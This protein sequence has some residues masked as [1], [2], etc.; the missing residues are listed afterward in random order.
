M[1]LGFLGRASYVPVA[2]DHFGLASAGY[3]HFT[4]P[5]RRYADLAVHR[6]IHA[7]LAGG[8]D[9][10]SFPD[11]ASMGALC[12]HINT[13][14]R[15]ASQAE[16]QMR[17]SLWMAQL[18]AAERD[19][20]YP[21]RVTGVGPKGVFVTLD[22]SRVSGM[23]STREL[24]GH[25]WSMTADGLGFSSASGGRLGYGDTVQVRVTSADVES[26]QLELRL[27]RSKR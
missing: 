18:A 26:G 23:V 27:V 14:A 20:V 3:L 4:S 12:G 19:T 13:A 21:A 2:G 16:N 24:P 6:V 22:R 11:A 7:F 17:K 1:L 8:R 25:G 10:D 9:A 15:T 5:I